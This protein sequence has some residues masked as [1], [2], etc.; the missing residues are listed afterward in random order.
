RR[1]LDLGGGHGEYALELARR[2]L[3]TTMQD[4]PE[5]VDLARRR[6]RLAAA[7]VELFAGDFFESIPPGPFD[8]VL[9]A[10]VV[11]TYG[12]GANRQLFRRVRPVV[13]PAGALA[14]HTFLGGRHPLAA[15]FAVQ[16]LAARPEGD[17]H[18]EEHYREWLAEA[19]Y[20]SVEV[21]E[22]ERPPEAVVL[23]FP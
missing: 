19:G 18:R 20:R 23:A 8:V 10:G 2:G 6:G 14:V 17:T 3:R 5:V 22:L 13:A 1:A 7:G 21:V 4:R 15:V 11:Y 12:P 9:C 16:M